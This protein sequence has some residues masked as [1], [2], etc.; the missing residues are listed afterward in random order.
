MMFKKDIKKQL[1]GILNEI[2]RHA[3]GGRHTMFSIANT[4]KRDKE[5][6]YFPPLRVTRLA[7]CGNVIVYNP[8]QAKEIASYVDGKV[9]Y[10]LVDAEKKIIESEYG[11]W[12]GGNIERLLKDT[13]KKSKVFTFKANDLTVDAIDMLLSQFVY[14]IGGKKV[15]IIGSGNIGSKIALRLVE[16]GSWVNITRRDYKKTLIIAKALNLIKPAQTMAVVRAFK[17]NLEAAKDADILIA[18]TAGEP[19]VNVAMVK[20]LNKDALIVDV[21]KGSIFKKAIAFAEKHGHT[22]LRLDIRAGF[23]GV[24][25]NILATEKLLNEVLGRRMVEGVNIVAGGMMGRRGDVIV[26][27]IL[28]PTRCIGIA[29]GMGDTIRNISEEDKLKT[30]KIRNQFLT[31]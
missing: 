4:K 16:R 3:V 29:D 15:A 11:D 22:V 24:V 23:E 20:L 25:A 13:V 30:E 19:A 6:L 12:I 14:K 21:G 26:D 8:Q 9:E 27:N 10:I 5:G 18:A 2:R 28:Q 17:S 7:V 31:V 1:N